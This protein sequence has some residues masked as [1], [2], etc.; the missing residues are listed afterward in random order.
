MSEVR[1]CVVAEA[2]GERDEHGIDVGAGSVVS[3]CRVYSTTTDGGISAAIAAGDRCRLTD[4]VC[5][6]ND[7]YGIYAG[8]ECVL[9]GCYAHTNLLDGIRVGSGSTVRD[10]SVGGNYEAGINVDG[11]NCLI[12][13]NNASSNRASGIYC[14]GKRNRI[15]DNHVAQNDW[16]VYFDGSAATDHNLAMRNSAI[17][18]TSGNYNP[19]SGNFIAP[20]DNT[21]AFTNAWSNF[22]F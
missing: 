2:H 1:H 9:I 14:K 8:S 3:H 10:C 12:V 16:G 13:G 21:G 22:S 7:H 15:D 18:N 11:D 19:G 5:E 6:Y 20:I 4:C 17:G